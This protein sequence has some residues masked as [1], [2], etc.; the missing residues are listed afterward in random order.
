MFGR[1]GL[2]NPEKAHATMGRICVTPHRQQLKVRLEL[3]KLKMGGGDTSQW[4]A[5]FLNFMKMQSKYDNN[6]VL[7]NTS[8]LPTKTKSRVI[9]GGKASFHVIA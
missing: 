4:G 5:V 8:E 7:I 3:E 2:E 1:R 9:N 6:H